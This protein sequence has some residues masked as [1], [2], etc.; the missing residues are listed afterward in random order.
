MK[1]DEKKKPDIYSYL[2]AF[3]EK[4]LKEKITFKN[5]RV[6]GTVPASAQAAD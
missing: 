2:G 6:A 5:R 3:L 1:E 4:K